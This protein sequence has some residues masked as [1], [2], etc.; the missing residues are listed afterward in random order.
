M[1]IEDW[2]D[3]SYLDEDYDPEAD[4]TCKFCGQQGLMWERGVDEHNRKR[5]HLLD[6]EGNIHECRAA[7]VSLN[8]F[9]ITP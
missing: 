8:S 9:P 4:I 7:P 3:F 5:W 6:Q 2:I 1:A